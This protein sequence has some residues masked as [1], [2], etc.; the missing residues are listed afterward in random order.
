MDSVQADLRDYRDRRLPVRIALVS[1]A[2]Y[3]A[4]PGER[5][6]LVALPAHVDPV[7]LVEIDSS[8]R[9]PCGGTHVRS[10]SELG[11]FQLKAP[12]PL[13]GK[14]V[15]LAFTLSAAGPPTPPA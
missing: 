15:R 12:I 6:G 3:E 14:D 7:R 4:E 8:D 9:C 1:R 2:E 13:A 11:E 10:T 5:S